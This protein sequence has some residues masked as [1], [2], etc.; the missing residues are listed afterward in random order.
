MQ[1]EVRSIDGSLDETIRS[2]LGTA[3]SV[4]VVGLS[5]DPNRPSHGV[6]SYLKQQG[7]RIIP[8]NPTVTEVLGER[9]FPDLR[10]VGQPVDVVDVF[11]RPEHV[12]A[13]VEE[14]IAIGAR[15]LWL[16]DGVVHE[17]AACRAREAG[18]TVVMDRCMKREHMRLRAAGLL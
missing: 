8:V 6:A 9:S 11:R 13:L 14:A 15:V 2:V 5:P 12:P 18:M 1:G 3:R 16:Q 7:Y 17:Q 4:A 10:A